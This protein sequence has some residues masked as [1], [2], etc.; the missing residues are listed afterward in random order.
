M[1]YYGRDHKLIKFE[2]TGFF[3]ELHNGEINITMS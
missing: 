1:F 2:D 3:L